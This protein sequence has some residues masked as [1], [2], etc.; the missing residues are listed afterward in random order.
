MKPQQTLEPVHVRAD[1]PPAQP[2]AAQPV[3][4]SPEGAKPAPLK[5]PVAKPQRPNIKKAPKQSGNNV[6][7]AIVATVI[8]VL[9]LA[10]LAVLAYL[11]TRK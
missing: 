11:K 7:A 5:A 3:P 10:A 9:G 2:A 1:Q 4:P 6:T 8:I